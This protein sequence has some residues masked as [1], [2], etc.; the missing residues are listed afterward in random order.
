M[1]FLRIAEEA[2]VGLD[3]PVDDSLFLLYPQ[4]PDCAIL[5]SESY[6]HIP[7]F[8]ILE[9]E[10]SLGTSIAVKIGQAVVDLKL[11]VKSRPLKILS[12]LV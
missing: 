12:V 9:L 2:S 1:W 10:F 8:V 4:I 7:D 5:L 3:S 11:E 6:P